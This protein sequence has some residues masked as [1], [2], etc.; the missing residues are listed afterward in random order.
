M[1]AE[2]GLA[3]EAA[4]LV[5]HA[6]GNHGTI[7]SGLHRVGTNACCS[8][9]YHVPMYALTPSSEPERVAL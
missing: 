2:V 6:D 4:W 3:L 9:A 8:E 5:S 1:V 7:A